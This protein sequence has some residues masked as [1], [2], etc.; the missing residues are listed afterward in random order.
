MADYAQRRKNM[1]DTQVRPADVTKYPIIAAMLKIPREVYLPSDRSEAAYISENVAIG[2]GRVMLEPRTFSKMLD[3]MGMSS[4]MLVLDIGCGYGYSAAV[5][6]EIAEAV[7]A[8]EEDDALASEA[9]TLLSEQGVD[10]VVLHRG[11]LAEGAPEHGPYDAIVVEGA[12]EQVPQTLIDQL[13]DGGRI[14]CVFEEDRL[15]VARIGYK[16]DG[17]VTWRFGFNAGAPVLPGF[18]KKKSFA[19]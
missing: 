1:I 7:V 10:N 3:W 13:K 12:V 5:I 16:L 9:E 17:H 8:V 14:A 15:G 4:D 2:P 6:A 11:P 18:E 19:L